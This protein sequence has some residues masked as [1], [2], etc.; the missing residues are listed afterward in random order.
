MM[1]SGCIIRS[2]AALKSGDAVTLQFADAK[3]GA[4]IDGAP[5]APAAPAPARPARPA[6]TKPQQGDLF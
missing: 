2:A 5:Q 1:A 4:V 3:R 6:A